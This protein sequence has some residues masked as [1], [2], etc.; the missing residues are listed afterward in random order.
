MLW[1]VTADELD[2]SPPGLERVRQ[3]KAAHE[4]TSADLIGCI[5]TKGDVLHGNN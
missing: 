5:D 4:M 2:L 1:Q 3:T